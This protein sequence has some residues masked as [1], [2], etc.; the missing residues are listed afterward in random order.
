M[1][2]NIVIIGSASNETSIGQT[3]LTK[4]IEKTYSFLMDKNIFVS[5]YLVDPEFSYILLNSKHQPEKMK[6]EY[7]LLDELTNLYDFDNNS[8]VS[9]IPKYYHQITDEINFNRKTIFISCLNFKSSYEVMLFTENFNE[10]NIY[11]N[12]YDLS[13][14]IDLFEI[15]TEFLNGDL[16]TK[17]LFSTK[18]LNISNKSD[19]NFIKS[20]FIILSEIIIYYIKSGFDELNPENTIPKI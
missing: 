10:E 3:P 12:H 15:S 18:K 13:E 2:L 19:F 20:N 6:N 5:I 9:I 16:K 8:I 7:K 17:N 14:K 1:E 4:N 11:Y